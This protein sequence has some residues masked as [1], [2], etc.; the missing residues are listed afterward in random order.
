VDVG[1]LEPG[2]H[3]AAVDIDDIGPRSAELTDLHL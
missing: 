2:H 1:V 3:H